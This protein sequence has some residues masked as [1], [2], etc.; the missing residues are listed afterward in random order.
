[1]KLGLRGV[2]IVVSSGDD[3]VIAS[4]ARNHNTAYCG[5][6]PDFPASSPFVTTVGA[7]DVLIPY[8]F[9]YIIC[10]LLGSSKWKARS[11]LS[12]Q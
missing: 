12:I 6:T 5:Y 2:T 11:C 9:E 8:V 1:M 3:G 4:Y 10:L 7:T